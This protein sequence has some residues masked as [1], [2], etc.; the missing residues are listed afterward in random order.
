MLPDADPTPASNYLSPDV[1]LLQV[2]LPA[3]TTGPVP[4]FYKIQ[5]QQI[6]CVNYYHMDCLQS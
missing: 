5:I 2:A 3:P 6:G 4:L 1:R